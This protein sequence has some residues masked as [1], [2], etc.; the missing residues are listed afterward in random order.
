MPTYGV[1][2]VNPDML[3]EYNDWVQCGS[4]LIDEVLKKNDRPI[5]LNTL[6]AGGMETFHV[7]SRNKKFKGIIG[8]TFLDK[9]SKDVQMMTKS[10]AF[11]G[12]FGTGLVGFCSKIGFGGFR[13]LSG[14]PDSAEKRHMDTVAPF[15]SFSC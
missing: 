4:D 8:M 3:F 1:T 11:Y 12:K 2:E 7:A 14:A 6:S 15:R 5:F 9:R 10:N 13:C